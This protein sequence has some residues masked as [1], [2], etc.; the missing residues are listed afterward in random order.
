MR[1][2]EK[3]FKRFMYLS[4]GCEIQ[5]WKVVFANSIAQFKAYIWC[6][7][8]DILDCFKRNCIK[9]ICPDLA[10]KHKFPNF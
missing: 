7:S 5:E 6:F 1:L 2:F 3:L 4:F 8:S 10:I 9:L